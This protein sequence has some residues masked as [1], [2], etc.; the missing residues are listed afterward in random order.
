MH[1]VVEIVSQLM[2]YLHL[3]VFIGGQANQHAQ[4]LGSN[5]FFTLFSIKGVTTNLL[6]DRQNGIRHLI[7]GVSRFLSHFS[8]GSSYKLFLK[9]HAITI[10]DRHLSLSP[11][12]H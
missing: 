10:A 8:Y 4:H 11:L 1:K 12:L 6:K 5:L 7:T 9:S 2:I 3:L